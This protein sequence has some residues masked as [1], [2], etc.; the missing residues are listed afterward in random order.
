MDE[1]LFGLRYA[2]ARAARSAA[3]PRAGAIALEERH[4][5]C[6]RAVGMHGDVVR[7][8]ARRLAPHE[9]VHHGRALAAAFHRHYNRYPGESGATGAAVAVAVAQVLE[10]VLALVGERGS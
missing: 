9:V 4:R 5:A 7:R 2:L 3:R 1:P 8:A 6:A 10:D